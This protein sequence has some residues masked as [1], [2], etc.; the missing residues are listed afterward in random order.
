M[1]RELEFQVVALLKFR[2]LVL[3]VVLFMYTHPVGQQEKYAAGGQGG[4]AGFSREEVGQN[5]Q[6]REKVAVV[7]F[8]PM[9]SSARATISHA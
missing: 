1:N 2:S 6:E 3:P 9:R 8:L 5:M 4:G 7:L